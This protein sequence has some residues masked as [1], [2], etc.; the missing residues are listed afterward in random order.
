MK[1]LH[2]LKTNIC[3]KST[4]ET[5][6]KGAIYVQNW[7]QRPRNN[8]KDIIL[9]SWFLTLKIFHSFFQ[10]FYWWLWIG[11]CLP[12]KI[13]SRKKI[14][15]SLIDQNYKLSEHEPARKY[16]NRVKK[17]IVFIKKPSNAINCRSDVISCS[18]GRSLLRY[19]RPVFHFY[20][21]WTC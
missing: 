6:E 5:L 9:V 15:W 17:L 2:F 1:H 20:T 13:F 10:S 11:K 4:K 8:V 16:L 7:Q 21:P 18:N 14:A 12:G 19:L 3:S